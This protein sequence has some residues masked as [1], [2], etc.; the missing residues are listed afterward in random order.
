MTTKSSLFCIAAV[1]ILAL[2][3]PS[4]AQI[5]TNGSFE[6]GTTGWTVQG[7]AAVLSTYGG[8]DGT[9]AMVFNGGDTTPNAVVS[10]TFST[11]PGKRYLLRYDYGALSYLAS[12]QQALSVSLQGATL[13]LSETNFVTT[14]SP[15]VSY[16]T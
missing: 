10:Q 12:Q 5:L 9:N 16:T 15:V 4:S 7:N 8:S 13:R 3:A 1:G 11:T 2:A 14:S 6:L